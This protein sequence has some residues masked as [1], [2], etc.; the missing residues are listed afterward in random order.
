ECCLAGALGAEV[1]LGQAQWASDA[2]AALFGEGA[3]GFVVSGSPTALDELV[4]RTDVHVLGTVGGETL[5]IA[6]ER[7]GDGQPASGASEIELTLDE[8]AHAH[9]QL[10]ELFA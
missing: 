1:E 5:S 6:I 4:A 10:A 3:G 9:A 2:T 7:S 8:L